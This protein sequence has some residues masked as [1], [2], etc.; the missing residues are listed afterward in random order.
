M[1]ASRRTLL[2]AALPAL[3]TARG[4]LAQTGGAV[5][6]LVVDEEGRPVSGVH[7]EAVNRS[8]PASRRASYGQSIKKEGSSGPDGRYRLDLTGMPPGEYRAQA[9]EAVQNGPSQ[10]IVELT[11]DTRDGFGVG[12]TVVRNFRREVIESSDEHPYG[13]AGIFVLEPAGYDGPD[14]SPAI[15]TLDPLGQ[16]GRPIVR[17]VRRTGEGLVV[18]GVPFGTYRASASLEGRPLQLQLALPEAEGMFAQS[19]E[20]AFTMGAFANQLR[21]FAKP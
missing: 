3:A 14:L 4:V 6:G 13:N 9:F 19:V 5:S 20:H 1:I 16:A 11:P 15:V 10:I 12:E 2:F 17:P 8:I 7:V 21:V 18:T